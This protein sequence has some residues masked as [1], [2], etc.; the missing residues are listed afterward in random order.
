LADN[1]LYPLHLVPLYPKTTPEKLAII[2]T[3]K[4]AWKRAIIVINYNI[5]PCTD[6]VIALDTLITPT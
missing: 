1:P 3:N 5:A 4:A 6:M 2:T